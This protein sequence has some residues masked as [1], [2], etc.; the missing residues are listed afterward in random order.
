MERVMRARKALLICSALTALVVTAP[1]GGSSA[2]GPHKPTLRQEIAR[3]RGEIAQLTTQIDFTNRRL[4]VMPG[5]GGSLCGDPCA[6][7][8]DGDGFN[9]CEDPCPCDPNVA[10]ADGD[11]IPDCFDP[12]P[13]DAA[14][15]CIDPC[16]TDADGDGIGDCEDPCPYDPAPAGDRDQDGL[17]DCQDPCPDDR[18]NACTDPCL[19]DQ[20]GDGVADCRDGCPWAPEI[21]VDGSV[22]GCL[23]PSARPGGA[24]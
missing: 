16:H 9:D 10:D 20:D 13:D 14:N 23:A 15:A 24:R 17:P 7:D 1:W 19:L 18:Q 4:E 11:Q 21:G 22:V 6:T 5:G 12:C 8:T 2:A 3:L